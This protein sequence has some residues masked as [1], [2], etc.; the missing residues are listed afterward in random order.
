MYLSKYLRKAVAGLAMLSVPV[1]ALAVP[2]SAADNTGPT[3]ADTAIAV[4]SL[5]GFDG[6]TGDFD[7]LLQALIAADLVGAVADADAD[8]TVFAPTDQAFVRLAR[9]LG[10]SERGYNEAGAFA[11]I[12]EQLTALGGGDPIPVLTDVLLYHVSPGSTFYSALQNNTVEVPTLLGVSFTA[13]GRHLI[14]EA[15]SLRNPRIKNP[16][17]DIETSNGVIHGINRV[18]L[19][20]AVGGDAPAP[21]PTPEPTPESGPTIADTAIAVSSLDGFDGNTG[22]FDMLLQ[23]LIAADLVGAVADADADLTVFAPTDQAF[24]RLARDLGYS[25]RGYNEAGAFAY[26]VEQLTALG[27]GDPIPVLTDVLLYHVSPGSTFYSALQNNT[28]EVPTLL[29]VSFTA[30]GR[31]L[32]DEATS[33][34]NPRIKNPLTDIET[35]NGVIHGINRVLI[36][37]GL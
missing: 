22:D 32:I 30:E 35:S 4:S 20:V 28:V 21:E 8:L 9:D 14:D 34:R 25:E 10:Y 23:A 33:L 17:T 12:V 24:V 16:L 27:G 36:P 6:N 7:M 29:G 19:P 31:H 26:I 1:A 5:D 37:L 18:L 3:I 15:T 13:E 2:A 11:Y